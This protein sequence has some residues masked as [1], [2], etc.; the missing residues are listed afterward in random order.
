MSCVVLLVYV[1][2]L[3]II[4]CTIRSAI[5]AIVLIPVTVGWGDRLDGLLLL[6]PLSMEMWKL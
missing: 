3:S 6:G 2:L 4:I 1:L 5:I